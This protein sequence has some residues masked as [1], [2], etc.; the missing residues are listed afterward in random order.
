MDDSWKKAEESVDMIRSEIPGFSPDIGIILGTGLGALGKEIKAEKE[1]PYR[2]IPHFPLS[3]VETHSGVLICGEL[4]GK[5]VVAMSGR[6]H[7][8]E[9]YSM[10]QIVFPV[11]VMHKL[12]IKYLLISNAAGGINPKYRAGDLA[13]I[14]DIINFTGDNPL[15]GPNNDRVGPRYPDMYEPTSKELMEKAFEAAEGLNVRAHMGGVYM[16]VTGP[17]LETRAEY[18]MM[19]Q[20]ADMVGMS[21]VPE[22]I[23]GVHCGLKILGISVITDE[24]APETLKPVNIENIIK[25]AM[26]A[27]P[28]LTAVMKAVVKNISV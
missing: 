22:I 16:G 18:R 15:I 27:E 23:A 28:K 1:I 13:L 24:C 21:T 10:K 9:G 7:R 14:D 19:G 4:E 2:D 3:T 17:N 12:G 20:F 25:T 11:R 26:K 5:K 8:Y 6:F